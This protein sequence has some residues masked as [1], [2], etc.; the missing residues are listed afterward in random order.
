MSSGT[1]DHKCPNCTAVLKFN[2]HE[3]NWKCEYCNSTFNKIEIEDYEKNRGIE[4]L[5]KESIP[6][7][8][9][10]ENGMD[11]Y[12]CPNC[13]AQIV[14][15]ENTSA[16]FCVYC[17]NTAILRNKLI[18]E[19]NPSKIIPFK[20]TREDAIETFKKFGKGKPFL[21]KIF[22]NEKSISEITGIYVPFWLYDYKVY[23]S[24][25]AE[26][27][28]I[29]HWTSGNYEYTKTDVYSVKREGN[30]EFSK[31]PVDGSFRLDNDLMNSIEPY[32]YNSLEE[33]NHSYL[34]GFFAEKYD[35]DSNTAN[36]DG[37]KRVYNTTTN[38]LK[39]CIQ[40]YTTVRVN[41]TDHTS[42]TL[43]Y[44]YVLLPVWLLNVKYKDKIYTLAMNGQTGKMVGN[45]ATDYWKVTIFFILLFSCLVII[46]S[47]IWYCIGV[48]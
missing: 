39:S 30:A 26:G 24:L 5:T 48:F 25:E 28:N 13:G 35:V 20:N 46:F 47:I 44:E 43:K 45:V 22:T 32:D 42:D 4:K 2:P 1:I 16:T 40:S 8:L 14:A 34:S 41:K 33:F 6:N 12:Y 7:K 38:L 3:Q 9:E 17:K 29:I 31:V 21:P 37:L 11:L 18:G 19:F 10:Q 15:D 23:G 27:K 36:V